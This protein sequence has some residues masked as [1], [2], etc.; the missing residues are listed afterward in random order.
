MVCAVAKGILLKNGRSCVDV[1]DGKESLSK[2]WTRSVLHRMGFTKQ[3]ACSKSKVLPQD[4]SE[5]H[6]QYLR[7]IK[8]VIQM[9]DIPKDL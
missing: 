4:V 7:K 9:E 2:E 5:I 3:R 6:Q 8:A 1:F